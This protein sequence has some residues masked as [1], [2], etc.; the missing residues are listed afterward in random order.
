[1]YQALYILN[2]LKDTTI[3]TN[4]DEP[5][6]RHPSYTTLILMHA[7]R[8]IFYPSNFIYLLTAR[9]LLQRP[10]LDIIKKVL[11]NLTCTAQAT[12]SLV[13]KFALLS[14]N[15]V[16]LLH[17][18]AES[19][20]WIR[21]LENILIV[22][23]SNSTNGEWRSAIGRCLEYLL[24]ERSCRMSLFFVWYW[25]RINPFF[26]VVSFCCGE[27]GARLTCHPTTF[28]IARISTQ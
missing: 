18:T 20:A 8:G 15:E 19:V 16:Q 10:E 7:L 27:P 11:A 9:F 21:I 3:Q 25:L 24:D 26:S 13:L 23:D 2:I 6:H 14:W 12:N 4:S 1:M 5:P 22:V 17:S 28:A